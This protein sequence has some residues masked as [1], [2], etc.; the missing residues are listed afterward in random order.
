MTYDRYVI[1]RVSCDGCAEEEELELSDNENIDEEEVEWF[2]ELQELGWTYDKEKDEHKC[3]LCVE[4][5]KDEED[6]LK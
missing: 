5:E 2:A 6:D 1:L 3:P 4:D